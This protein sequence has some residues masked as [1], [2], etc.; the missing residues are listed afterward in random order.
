VRATCND[1]LQF[2]GR[3][4]HQA[5]R[6]AEA[7]TQRRCQQSCTGRGADQGEGRQVDSHAACGGA[8]ADDEVELEILHRGIQDFLDRRLQAVDLVDEQH[9]AWLQVG[10]NRREVAGALDHRAGGGAKAHA[11]FAGHDLRQRGFAEAG[12]P[13]QQHVIHRLAT[14]AGGLDEDREV[15]A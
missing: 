7:V 9:V 4:E 14:G 11:E 10:Q 12:R 5:Q 1:E 6:N 8:F 2:G 3:V 13:V 15:F